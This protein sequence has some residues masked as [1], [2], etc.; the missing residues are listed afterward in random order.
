VVGAGAVADANLRLR[1]RHSASAEAQ[2]AALTYRAAGERVAEMVA[3]SVSGREL[4]AAGVAED[5]RLATQ[6]DASAVVPRL[7]D[8]VLVSAGSTS[9]P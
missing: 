3:G 9:A 6:V 5:V 4:I 1:P 7:V 8:G 2:L